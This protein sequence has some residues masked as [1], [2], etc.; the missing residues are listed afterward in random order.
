MRVSWCSIGSMA[1][2]A[3]VG[4]FD[5]RME[6]GP[7]ALGNRSILADARRT[8]G[9]FHLNLRIKYRESW[10]PFAPIVARENAHRYFELDDGE[11]S[12]YMLRVAHV[13]P[14]LRREV[15]WAGF[16]DDGGGDMVAFL[17]QP[18]SSIPAVTH[19]D[20]SAR[21]QTVDPQRHPTLHKLLH[22]F[23][24]ITGCGV[25]INTSFNRRGEPIVCTPKDAIDC[26][27]A[28]GIDVLAIGPFI[29]RK[30]DQ[31]QALRALEG[32]VRF[33]PD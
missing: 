16:R 1:D 22:E 24:A 28:T 25:L 10:R 11:D 31:P 12:P 19:V 23:E 33:E 8:D 5:G 7:R 4:R 30:S 29:V 18:R 15:D 13:R 3:I 20:H 21:V 27:L 26:F 2:G 14:E 32:T 9:Q 17:Q 6:F